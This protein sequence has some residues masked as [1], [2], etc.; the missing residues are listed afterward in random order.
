M[1]KQR[2]HVVTMRVTFDKPTGVKAA[3]DAVRDCIHGEFYPTQFD[4]SQ[5]GSF[6]VKSV[7]PAKV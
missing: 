4:D 3:A 6:K 1:K 7:R 2:T 5:P